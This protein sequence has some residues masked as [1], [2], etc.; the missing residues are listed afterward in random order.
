MTPLAEKLEELLNEIREMLENPDPDAEAWQ[1][2]GERREAIFCEIAEMDFEREENK[3]PS[4]VS[5]LEE[6][7]KQDKVVAEKLKKKLQSLKEEISALAEAHRAMK[8]YALSEPAILF[9]RQA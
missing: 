9:E 5:L 2:Y 4:V 7:L 3:G 6:I 8:G 1:K